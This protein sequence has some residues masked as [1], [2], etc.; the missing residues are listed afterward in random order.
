MWHCSVLIRLT[1]RKSPSSSAV[2]TISLMWSAKVNTD[3]QPISL[4]RAHLTLALCRS[5]LGQAHLSAI[6]NEK[7]KS[8]EYW[9]H[10]V[11][12]RAVFLPPSY[13]SLWGRGWVAF[14]FSAGTPRWVRHRLQSIQMCSMAHKAFLCRSGVRTSLTFWLQCEFFFFFLREKDNK[15][16]V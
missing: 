3:N 16:S 2:E 5:R 13:I 4:L 15:D 7:K 8:W 10:N 1:L 12:S 14:L 9:E 6:R 11:G